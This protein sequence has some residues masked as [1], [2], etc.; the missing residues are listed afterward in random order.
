M[1][2]ANTRSSGL[3]LSLVDP[4]IPTVGINLVINIYAAPNIPNYYCCGSNEQ[5]I[6]T[7]MCGSLSSGGFTGL[8]SGT[9]SGPALFS[10]GSTKY[11]IHGSP[12]TRLGDFLVMNCGN[13]V[14]AQNSPGQT[15][16]FINV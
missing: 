16:Y 3:A 10:C 4:M 11:F 1:T 14:G 8:I 6:S 13:S 2:L 9:H 7:M 12:A 15:K 5:N